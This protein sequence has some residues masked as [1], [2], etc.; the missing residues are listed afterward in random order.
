MDDTG[1]TGTTIDLEDQ[2]DGDT[3]YVKVDRAFADY[4]RT[5]RNPRDMKALQ[6]GLRGIWKVEKFPHLMVA[7]LVD[8]VQEEY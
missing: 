1:V 4:R 5:S 3:I 7:S 6:D 2:D 8:I